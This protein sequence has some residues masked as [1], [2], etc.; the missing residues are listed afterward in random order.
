MLV[1]VLK[2]AELITDVI[3]PE[4]YEKTNLLH[5]LVAA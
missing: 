3:I 2:Q 4:F 5:L 1:L